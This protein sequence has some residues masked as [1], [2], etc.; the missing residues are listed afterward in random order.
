MARRRSQRTESIGRRSNKLK[1]SED[2]YE[3]T[4]DYDDEWSGCGTS[5]ETFE[6]SWSELQDYIKQLRASGCYNIDAACV[7]DCYESYSGLN[8]SSEEIA[9]K[10]F[11][12][13]VKLY[14][15]GYSVLN[16]GNF[17]CKIAAKDD[18]DA[19]RQF[20]DFLKTDWKSAWKNG[21]LPKYFGES[22]KC[23]ARRCL[24]ED[25]RADLE[26]DG[27][28]YVTSKIFGG[29]YYEIYRKV[30]KGENKGYWKAVEKDS[31]TFKP[32]GEPFDIT[33]EQASGFEPIR[34][35]G[36]SRAVGKALGFTKFGVPRESYRRFRG[37]HGTK[38]DW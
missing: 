17:V 8:E 16:D 15:Y 6:G 19:I 9:R 26:A 13:L 4:Y 1:I 18:E 33:W 35:T 2:V 37:K 7:D 28:K 32:I 25:V 5:S 38:K 36:F 27:Y 3:I 24:R 29:R 20:N 34:D 14:P 30:V 11:V 10:L 21:T 23:V 12:S 31:R 22:K